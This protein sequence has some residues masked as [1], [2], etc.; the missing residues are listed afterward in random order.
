MSDIR[1][2]RNVTL[3][4]GRSI[5]EVAKGLVDP[6]DP[7]DRGSLILED[8]IDLNRKAVLVCQDKTGEQA[9]RILWEVLEV[10]KFHQNNPESRGVR[11]TGSPQVKT[12]I[13]CAE[14]ADTG[15]FP[16]LEDD[17]FEGFD[18]GTEEED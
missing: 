11:S 14:G 16:S 1:D 10:E 7:M 15:D 4:D 3:D 5:L 8:C 13:S 18:K 17:F 2:P 6:F 9:R 12:V